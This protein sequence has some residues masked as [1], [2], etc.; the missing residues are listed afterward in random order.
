M[1]E[2]AEGSAEKAV[3]RIRRKGV[4]GVGTSWGLGRFKTAQGDTKTTTPSALERAP[5]PRRRLRTWGSGVRI[6]AAFRTF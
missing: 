6:P 3:Q 2:E 1:A 5:A 4:T